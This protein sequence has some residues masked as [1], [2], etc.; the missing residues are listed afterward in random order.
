VGQPIVAAEPA[1]QR[2]A[3]SAGILRG[4]PPKRRDLNQWARHMVDVVTGAV[5]EPELP[6]ESPAAEPGRRDG[7]IGGK[8]RA[9]RMSKKQRSA[10]AQKAAKARWA[11]TPKSFLIYFNNLITEVMDADYCAINKSL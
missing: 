9:S 1:P 10:A 8:I 4:V 3:E 2:P 11:K 5:Q 6:K 7:Q